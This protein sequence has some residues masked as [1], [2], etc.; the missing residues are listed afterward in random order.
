MKKELNTI[1]FIFHLSVL[2]FKNSQA[3]EQATHGSKTK[4]SFNIGFKY[5][6][7]HIVFNPF[8]KWG[9]YNEGSTN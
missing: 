1:Y 7:I 2:Q 5:Q 9:D 3:M 4:S 8:V 6:T